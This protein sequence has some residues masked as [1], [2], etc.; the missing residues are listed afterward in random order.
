MGGGERHMDVRDRMRKIAGGRS[1]GEVMGITAGTATGHDGPW[2]GGW[3]C[4]VTAVMKGSCQW[5]AACTNKAGNLGGRGGGREGCAGGTRHAAGW[6]VP[7]CVRATCVRATRGQ[8]LGAW[9]GTSASCRIPA[10]AAGTWRQSATELAREGPPP[11]GDRRHGAD[12][13]MEDTWSGVRGT[14]SRDERIWRTSSDGSTA[15]AHHAN[16]SPQLDWLAGTPA[17]PRA[18]LRFPAGARP[19][20]AT[21]RTAARVCQLSGVSAFTPLG[22][23]RCAHTRRRFAKHRVRC[24]K[25]RTCMTRVNADMSPSPGDGHGGA[26]HGLVGGGEGSG[27]GWEMKRRRQEASAQASGDGGC[28]GGNDR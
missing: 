13:R 17:T 14:V 22:T 3:R 25:V 11:T 5:N 28:A 26:S 21:E 10:A 27:G 24:S 7:Q 8:G 1:D 20:G 16:S 23:P 9:Q 15:S 19:Q 18:L 12:V 6:R 2:P 4:N